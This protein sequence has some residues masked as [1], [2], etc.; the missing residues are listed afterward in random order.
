MEK[1]VP[2]DTRRPSVWPR[3]QPPSHATE[4]PSD[5]S[6]PTSVRKE[7]LERCQRTT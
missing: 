1:D 7:L 3:S 4:G 2:E 6:T 5:D